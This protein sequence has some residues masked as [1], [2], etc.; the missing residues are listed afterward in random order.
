[1]SPLRVILRIGV[2]KVQITLPEP[3]RYIL[4]MPSGKTSFEMKGL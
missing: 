4:I 1:M 3:L 2:A